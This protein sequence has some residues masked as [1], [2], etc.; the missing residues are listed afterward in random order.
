[1]TQEIEAVYTVGLDLGQSN[2]FTALTVLEMQIHASA[3]LLDA[4]PFGKGITAGWNSPAGLLRSQLEY[5]FLEDQ[6]PWLAKPPVHLRHLERMR[7][8]SYPE[9]VNDIAA[10]L[11]QP[12]LS[13]HGYSLV[14]DATGVGA[15]VVDLFRQAEIPVM[16]VTIH[17]GD[18]V[19]RARG[20]FRVPKRDLVAAVQAV[21]QTGRLLVAEELALWPTLKAEL[22]NFRVTI[23]PRTAHDSYSHWREGQHDDLV[24]SLALAVWFRDM[25]WKHWDRQ[26]IEERAAE[27][28]ERHNGRC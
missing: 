15:P 9:M 28:L 13:T 1:M 8:R 3:A 25:Y 23:D 16:A 7:G 19:N 12:P 21:M 26:R 10:L 2:D 5:V 22:Q 18:S 6:S 27:H 24:L 20:G 14:V 11:K 4:H 17:G